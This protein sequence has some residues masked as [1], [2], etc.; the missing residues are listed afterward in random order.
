MQK[1]IVS[2]QASVDEKGEI[3]DYVDN[4]QE[5]QTPKIEAPKTE[6][7]QQVIIEEDF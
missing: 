2:D 1:A 7:A 5:I 3:V 4:K 6:K